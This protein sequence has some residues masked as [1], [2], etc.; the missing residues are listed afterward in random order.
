MAFAPSFTITPTGNPAAFTVVDTSTGSD[1][2]IVDRQISLFTPGNVLTCGPI[3]FPLSAGSSITVAPLTTDGAFNV[4]VTWNNSGGPAIYT[5]SLIFAF[6][7]YGL[8][9][10]QS[11]TQSQISNPLIVNDNSWITN[12][13]SIFLEI[14]SALNSIVT[15]QSVGAAQSC[16]LRY[17][18][19]IS[20]QNI[21]F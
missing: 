17:L 12:K 4:I 10:L 18:S 11:L 1:G 9:F 6:V 2:A 13:L 5:A 3:D 14:K 8:Q 15:G 16:I 20:N 21:I 19:T 7:Q